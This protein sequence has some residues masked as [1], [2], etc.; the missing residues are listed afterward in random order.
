MTT[1]ARSDV[2]SPE[3]EATGDMHGCTT[4]GHIFG[5]PCGVGGDPILARCYLCQM[6]EPDGRLVT[7]DGATR[8]VCADCWSRDEVRIPLDMTEFDDE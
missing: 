1:Y 7:I 8:V 4:E 2:Y 5:C 6:T 3:V